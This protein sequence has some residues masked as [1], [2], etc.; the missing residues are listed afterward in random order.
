MSTGP[1]S[2]VTRPGT[3]SL[4]RCTPGVVGWWAVFP[5]SIDTVRVFLHVLA[6]TVWVG[7]QLTLLGLLP[8]VRSLGG[9]APKLV[10]R[11]FGVIAWSAFALA[12]LTGIWNIYAV[13]IVSA[14]TEY[15]VTLAVK[16]LLVTASGMGAAV[17][18]FATSKLALAIGGAVG[19]L[20]ALGA[21][22]LGVLLRVH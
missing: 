20:G 16:L 13:D 18:S 21:L 14:T 19:L 4:E 22:F 3:W 9:D 12:V 8:T 7:G 11:Q 6:V 10:G 15:Q 1:G 5:I 17:H 2:K